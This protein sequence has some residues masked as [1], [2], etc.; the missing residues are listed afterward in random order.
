MTGRADR[1]PLAGL[2][3]IEARRPELWDGRAGERIAEV[4]VLAMLDEQRIRPTGPLE[5]RLP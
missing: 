2:K 4:I 3:V 1:L 5:I